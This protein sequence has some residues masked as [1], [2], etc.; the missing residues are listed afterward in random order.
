MN[1]A[2]LL[3]FHPSPSRSKA[4]ARLL[5]AVAGR[6]DIRIV[7]MRERY[8]EGIKDLNEDGAREIEIMRSTRNLILQFPVQWYS[9]PG[10]L[11]DWLDVVLTRAYYIHPHTEGV[12]LSS[13]NVWLAMT[14]GNT[15]DAYTEHGQNGFQMDDILTP[16]KAVAF[17]AGWAWHSP[18][19]LYGANRLTDE[20]L[21][22]AALEY[23]AYIETVLSTYPIPST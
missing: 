15:P 22:Q 19:I 7:S 4:N 17:R 20:A 10:L 2:T 23:R 11:K 18:Y 13:L 12:T 16:L 21:S 6:T 5:S 14:A 8:P 3:N 1:K 9:V